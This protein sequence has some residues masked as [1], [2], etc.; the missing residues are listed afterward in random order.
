MSEISFSDPREL[1][2]QSD[3]IAGR[4]EIGQAL[5]RMAVEINAH[6]GDSDIILLAVMTGAI[7]PATWIATRLN[8]PLRMDFVHATRYSGQT[9]GGELD[10][11][12]PPRL[13]LQD[14]HVLVVDDIYDVGLTLELI[15]RYC[16]ARGA[17]SVNSAV[18]VRKQHGRETAGEL[19]RFIGM[20]VD[21]RYVF[22]CGMD[23]HEHWRHLT[24]LRA[25]EEGE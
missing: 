16:L 21:D 23:V 9:Q 8:M 6:Y 24:E 18:L 10:F 13:N 5:D 20:D 25:L 22:G 12:V 4:D 15:E 11:R 1:L 19:P 7:L 14:Q 2:E 17:R 3:L